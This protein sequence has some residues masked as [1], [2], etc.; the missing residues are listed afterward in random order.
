MDFKLATD[1]IDIGIFKIDQLAATHA[2]GVEHQHDQMVTHGDEVVNGDLVIEQV[3][4]LRL[5]DVYGKRL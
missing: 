2:G 3:L 5:A 1:G 4:H